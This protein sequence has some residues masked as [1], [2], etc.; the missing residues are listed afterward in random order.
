MLAGSRLNNVDDGILMNI[1]QLV[2]ENWQGKAE[3]LGE[4]L[5]Q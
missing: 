5:A 3:V 4:I 1:E 2:N